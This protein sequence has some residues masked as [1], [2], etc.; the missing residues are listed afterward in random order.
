MVKMWLTDVEENAYRQVANLASLPF[1]DA[2]R[3]G[4]TGCSMGAYR[5]W[6]L[7]A[8]SDRVKCGAAVCWS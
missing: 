1:V 3:I 2:Q 6:M 4:C 7:A 5:T 8:L